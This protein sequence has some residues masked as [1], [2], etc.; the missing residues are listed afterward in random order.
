MGI[1]TWRPPVGMVYNI[2]TNQYERR[3]MYKRSSRN[4]NQYWERPE[5]PK[6]YEL[7]R[8]KEIA[9]QRTN[10]E[11]YNPELQEYRNQE[12]DRRLNGFWFYNNG[13]P[14]YITGLHYFYL[15]HWKI[16]VGYPDFR[17]TDLEFFYFSK[18]YRL[19]FCWC[20]KPDCIYFN[21]RGWL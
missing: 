18:I 4:D 17:V 3:E 1:S 13:K 20:P 12:W 15:V 16:D 7:K 10:A 2:M 6:D 5:P 14:T 9:T 8:K 21:N 11:Y 19:V